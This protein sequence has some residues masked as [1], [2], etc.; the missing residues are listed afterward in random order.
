MTPA[1]DG[2]PARVL[3]MV[4][5][6]ILVILWLFTTTGGRQVFVHEMLGDAYDSQAAHFLRGDVDVDGEAIRHEVMVVHGHSRMYFGPFP[7][8][9]RMALNAI[10]PAGWGK[11]S[12]ISGYGA[13]AIALCSFAAL[14]ERALR[15]SA[16][17]AGARSWLGS[18]C[19]TGFAFASPLLLLLG[20][21]SIYN[22]A[23]IWGLAGALAALFFALRSREAEGQALTFSLLGF[24]VFAGVALLSRI[25]FGLPLVLI[26]PALAFPIPRKNRAKLL[27]ALFLPLSVSV[28]FSLWLSYA[29]FGTLSGVDLDYYINPAHREFAR[30]YGMLNLR[31]VPWAFTDYFGVRFP[32]VTSQFPFFQAQRHYSAHPRLFS[33]PVSEVYLPVTLAS[34]WLVLPTLFGLT[35]LIR[36]NGSK[37]FQRWAA[38]A[39]LAEVLCILSYFALAE[40][41]AADFYPFLV[42]CLVLFLASASPDLLRIR[43]LIIL[44]VAFSALINS[45]TTISW[46][47]DADQNVS[48]ETRAAWESLLGPRRPHHDIER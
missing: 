2:I 24:S 17:S 35:C 26:A 44:L 11:W 20:N 30:H 23:I 36:P 40:R 13:G 37:L 25:T 45:L 16:L 43:H 31:R 28:L 9:L 21:L 3:T 41:Y 39:L 8:F 4:V 46:L 5:L 1:N 6:V 7:A 10:Y 29:R 27:S 38:L 18:A 47:I 42:F 33:V 22:E 14:I 34:A 12:R 15:I 19:V 32:S 48:A